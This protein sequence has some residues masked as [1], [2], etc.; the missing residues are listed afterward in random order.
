VYD[1]ATGKTLVEPVG[2]RGGLSA[3]GIGPD[4]KS[5]VTGGWDG[6]YRWWD[7]ATGRLTREVPTAGQ[8]ARH[9][10]GFSPDARRGTQMMELLDAVCGKVLAPLSWPSHHRR[11]WTTS[12][13]WLPDGSV[14]IPYAECSAVRF[15]GDGKALVEYVVA[16]A[17]EPETGPTVMGVAISPDGKTVVLAGDGPAERGQWSDTGWVAM[18]DAATGKKLRDWQS[19]ATGGFACASYLPDG[20]RVVLG[21]KVFQPVR[22]GAALDLPAALVLFDP[23]AGTAVTPFDAPDPAARDRWVRTVAVSPNGAQVAAVEWDNAITVYETAGGGI[24]RRLVGHRGPVGQVAFTPDG[25][26]LVSVSED[27]TGLVWDMTPPRPAGPVA[28]REKAWAAL[29]A[30]DA[31]AAH[32]A[33]GELAA[34]PAGTVAFLKAHLKPTPAPTD[35]DLDRLLAGLAAPAFADREAAARDLD[36]FGG[37]AVTKVRDRLAKVTSADVRQRLDDF[38]KRHDRP[39]RTTGYRLRERRAVEL[40]DAIGTAEAR[41]VLQEWAGRGSGGPR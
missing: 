6:A 34:A 2:P 10:S 41:G 23:A 16:P 24:R 4:G 31:V 28:D 11:I 35:A 12:I 13:G 8:P 27:G 15:S 21:R 25:S 33:M 36:A 18:F 22:A 3:V 17:G 38:L 14:V 37:L 5:V 40:L 39:G 30:A 29:L 7:L 32:R 1:A 26:R 9:A 20:S 19:K